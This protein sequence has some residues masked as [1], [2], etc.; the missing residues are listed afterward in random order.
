ML[1][2]HHSHDLCQAE[3]PL[4]EV[5]PSMY[6]NILPDPHW[7]QSGSIHT[8]PAKQ[9]TETSSVHWYTTLLADHKHPP[10][11]QGLYAQNQKWQCYSQPQRPFW[12]MFK[13]CLGLSSI[14]ICAWC[15][16]RCMGNRLESKVLSLIELF[17]TPRNPRDL[18]IGRPI[19]PG[20]IWT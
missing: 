11:L 14:H 16:R 13:N 8:D 17:V 12:L 6:L 5:T 15:S 4:T 18:A 20:Q 7:L 9:I 19:T 3:G 1:S 10:A 2:I